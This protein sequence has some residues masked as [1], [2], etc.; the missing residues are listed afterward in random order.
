MADITP[1]QAQEIWEQHQRIW[2]PRMDAEEAAV[3]SLGDA[4]GYGRLMQ[5][6]E[7]IWREKAVAQG[8]PGSEHTTGPCAALMVKCGCLSHSDFGGSGSAI[9]W[10]GFMDHDQLAIPNPAVTTPTSYLAVR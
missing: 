10:V 6:A 8:T 3:K 2:K 4:I 7:T 9:Q 5:A 1:E